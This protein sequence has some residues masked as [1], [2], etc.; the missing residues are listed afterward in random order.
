MVMQDTVDRSERT[1]ETD[2]KRKHSDPDCM[3]CFVAVGVSGTV[4][5]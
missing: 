1:Q 3:H 4:I 5:N 2:A